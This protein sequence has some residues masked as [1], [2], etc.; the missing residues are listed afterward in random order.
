M[1]KI[2]P[3]RFIPDNTK[4]NFMGISKYNY[5]FSIIIIVMSLLMV[6]TRGINFGIDFTG[7]AIIEAKLE[8]KPDLSKLYE[9]LEKLDLGDIKI[10]DYDITSI[11]IRIG[12]KSL[13]QKKLL[14][15]IEGIKQQLKQNYDNNIEFRKIDFVGP[16]VGDE[17][18]K[19]GILAVLF[20]GFAILI[21]VAL[22]FEWQYGVGIIIALIHDIIVTL[23][24]ISI[25]AIEFDLTII[26]AILTIIGYSVND[27]VV[28]YDR[29]RE[30]FKKFK[31]ISIKEIINL[32]IN[33]TLSRTTLTVFS[34][35]VAVLALIFLGGPAIKGF[36][37]V[38]FVGILVGTYSSI[39]I[40]APILIYLGLKKF[41]R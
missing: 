10:Q 8:N 36:S 41:V 22:R 16:Q 31:K 17:L 29:I 39:Y 14:D 34:T 32:S 9:I 7:G 28:I 40:S 11:M 38:T 27:S 15:G 26:A 23:G 21:Y 3:L 30:N 35:L 6:S 24:F 2:F 25:F 18:I 33:E 4:I 12:G 1:I 5:L 13:G 19:N 20:S 37:I